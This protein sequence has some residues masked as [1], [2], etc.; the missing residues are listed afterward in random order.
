MNSIAHISIPADDP[1]A[2]ARV[3][4]EILAGEALLFPPGGKGAWKVF[5]GDGALDLEIIQRGNVIMLDE[6]IEEGVFEQLSSPQRATECHLAL[7][8]D[9]PESEVIEIAERAGWFARHCE[10][11][12]GIFGLAE[13]WVDGSFMIEVLDPVQTARYREH[14]TA[15]KWKQYLPLMLGRAA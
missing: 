3:L 1:A 12:G 4:A 15:E 13:I 10:R 14:V 2:T 7:C 11:G 6:S 9:R 5:S 8:V